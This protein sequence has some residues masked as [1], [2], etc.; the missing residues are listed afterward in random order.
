METIEKTLKTRKG[1]E[2]AYFKPLTAGQQLKLTRG[3]KAS[4]NEDGKVVLEMDFGDALERNYMLLHFTHVDANGKQVY[5]SVQAVQNEDA[6]RV[7]KLIEL[8]QEA[9][10][11]FAEDSGN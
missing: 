6:Q 5:P 1:E 10:K 9:A 4:R 8:A 11:E 3:Q 7:T 2:T